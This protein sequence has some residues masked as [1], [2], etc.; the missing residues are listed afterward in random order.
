MSIL[1]EPY[2]TIIKMMPPGMR[3]DFWNQLAEFELLVDKIRHIGSDLLHRY[4]VMENSCAIQTAIEKREPYR[5]LYPCRKRYIRE[6]IK[7]RLEPPK[8]YQPRPYCR[9]VLV[10][11]ADNIEEVN[12]AKLEFERLVQNGKAFERGSNMRL[13]SFDPSLEEIIIVGRLQCSESNLP[14]LTQIYNELAQEM[15]S[16]E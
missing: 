6:V 11:N 8:P 2:D 5:V 1:F 15:S 7:S 10:W 14:T 4:V 3:E 16:I 9:R 13:Q 12:E